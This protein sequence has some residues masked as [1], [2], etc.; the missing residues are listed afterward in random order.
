MDKE[1]RIKELL[2]SDGFFLCKVFSC[3]MSRISCLKIAASKS[4]VQCLSCSDRKHN[5][6]I[7]GDK[8]DII[9]PFC[10][11]PGCPKLARYKGKCKFHYFQS[12][13]MIRKKL[14]AVGQIQS[15]FIF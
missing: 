13:Y 15:T 5:A 6:L 1:Q 9:T 7:L 10:S 12:Y 3:R 14:K 8:I 4:K 11:E 2:E